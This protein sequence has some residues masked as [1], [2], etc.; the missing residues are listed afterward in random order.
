MKICGKADCRYPGGK[1]LRKSASMQFMC[2]TSNSLK[3]VN[4]Q[5]EALSL[6]LW[7]K[8]YGFVFVGTN[9]ATIDINI[10]DIRKKA[11]MSRDTMFTFQSGF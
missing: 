10:R 5:I 9:P 11:Q 7:L 6:Q 4:Y 2:G 3:S 8:M 1:R